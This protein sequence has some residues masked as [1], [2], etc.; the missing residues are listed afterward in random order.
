[1]P[2]VQPA[3]HHWGQVLLLI[4]GVVMLLTA[5]AFVWVVIRTCGRTVRDMM[6]KVETCPA[7]I[8]DKR[9]ETPRFMVPFQ[10]S[11]CFLTFELDDRR[12]LQFGLPRGEWSDLEVGDRGYLTFQGTLYRGFRLVVGPRADE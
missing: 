6:T 3:H 9:E 2:I 12:R 10:I 5:V 8:I 7:Q 11:R 4:W 1:V